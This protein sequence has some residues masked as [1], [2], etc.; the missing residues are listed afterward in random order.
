MGLSLSNQ[1]LEFVFSAALG[2]VLGF[3]YD[4]LR[5]IR[6]NTRANIVLSLFDLLYWIFAAAIVVWFAMTVQDGQLRIFSALGAILGSVMYFLVLSPLILKLGFA[7]ARLIRRVLRFIFTPIV[8]TG[9]K[10][11]ISAKN[12]YEKRKRH[13][14]IASKGVL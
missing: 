4:I 2:V 9:R 7:F 6:G 1:T 5:V 11:A 8:K 12:V 3:L 10:M 14:T 13:F